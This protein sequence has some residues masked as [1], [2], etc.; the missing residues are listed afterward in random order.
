MQRVQENPSE[1]TEAVA[2]G[3]AIAPVAQP[4]IEQQQIEL[5]FTQAPAALAAAFIV[6]VVLGVSL[7]GVADQ[8]LLLAWL[9]VQLLLTGMRLW[10][11]HCYRRADREARS[12]PQWAKF[13][14]AGT[15]LSGTAWGCIG[16]IYSSGWEVQYQVLVIICLIGL[17][18][19]AVSS[20]SA[21]TGVY[22]AF[23]APS[24]LIFTQSLLS[25]PGGD[26]NVMGLLFLVGGAV[27]LAISRNSS[28]SI[29]K[30]LQLRHEYGDLLRK[31]AITNASLEMEISTRQDAESELLQERQLFTEGPV[32]VYRCR[33]ESGWP[34]EYVSE[35]ISGF[36]YEAEKIMRH[37]LPFADLIYPD[38]L[39]R[40]KE[41]E[42]LVGRNGSLSLGIDYRLLCE[43]GRVRWIYDY[44]VPVISESGEIT[45]YSGYMLDITERKN[46]EFELQ[47]EKDRIQVTLHSIADAVITTDVNG[48]VEYLNPMAEQ[49]TGW[50]NEIARGLPV[51]RIFCLFDED[52]RELIESPVS[53][54][55]AT[56]DI[57]K[58]GKD[59]VLR[60]HGGD[61]FSIQCSV[62]PIKNEEGAP[63]GVIIVF[64]DVT[65]ARNMEKTISYQA[66]H[67]SLTGL[68]NRHEF[69]MQIDHALQATIAN[70][71]HHA[72]C[73]LNIDQFKIINDTCSHE[74]GDNMLVEVTGVLKGCLRDSDI[75][76]RIGGD[77]FGV[78]LKNCSLKDA[79]TLADTMLTDVRDMTLTGCRGGFDTSVS[80]GVVP[81][82]R[83]SVNVTSIMSAADLAC[84]AAKDFGGNRLH[85]YE[86]GDQELV[87][88]HT[89]MQWVSKLTA[90][91]DAD[92][93][94]LYCQEIVPIRQEK[95]AGCHF[96]V[97]V[98]M[99]DTSGKVIPPGS[100]LPAAERY[101][102]ITGLD[103]WVVSHS[104]AWYAENSASIEA[105]G[106][107]TMSINLSGASVTDDGFM[108]FIKNRFLEYEVDP[109]KICFEI[110]ETAAIANL[111]AAVDFIGGLKKLGCRF[112]LDD[113]GSGLSSFAYLKNF[114]VDYLKID[115]SF[116]RHMETD[117]VDRAM[118]SAIRQLGSLVGIKTIAEF[119]E[120]DEILKRLAEIG[121]DYAQGYGISRPVPL[122]SM[123]I[124]VYKTA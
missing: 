33:A 80:I 67:D 72:L 20:Y 83:D 15:L 29:F 45:H 106:L 76:S 51:S 7:W 103:R 88:R 37:Q 85:V 3:D 26:H 102:M 100:F 4:D 99:L 71:E 87:R 9:G 92:R 110:T 25:Q 117:A 114:P 79:V 53:Q 11:V 58:S 109:G 32:V 97:L 8:S 28:R 93:L 118:V 40:V 52:S 64:T 23:M 34:V 105:G 63:L 104:F 60:Q 90:A 1:W 21:V 124:G 6:A 94:V 70:N 113:F 120:N 46:S 59:L 122:S 112:S 98:R 81:V 78:L 44:I 14:L 49:M 65:E 69:E 56:S 12:N 43:D 55:L 121:V 84:Y 82:N 66:A 48:Q 42:L 86:A 96:E 41:S 50:V 95:Y 27:L 89:E 111:D 47:Q 13:F 19:G 75:L 123:V 57:V 54:C 22:I 16:L 115:G 17:Q 91:I 101:N 36:G 2:M 24:I 74:A 35:T 62:S 18:A 119:V 73:Y 77:E 5:V 68:I 31:M 108:E 10:H 39:Q 38:D 30:S 61:K 116:V 107:D